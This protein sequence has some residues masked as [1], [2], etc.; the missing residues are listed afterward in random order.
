MLEWAARWI[1]WITW[2]L[3]VSAVCLWTIQNV[4]HQE[5]YYIET[6]TLVIAGACAILGIRIWMPFAS[7]KNKEETDDTR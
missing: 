1:W 7:A 4:V 3:V 2:R 6:R 5:G